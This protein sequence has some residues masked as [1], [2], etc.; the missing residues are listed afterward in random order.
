MTHDDFLPVIQSTVLVELRL[1]PREEVAAA[2]RLRGGSHGEG[3][4]HGR[5]DEDELHGERRVGRLEVEGLN[6][7]QWYAGGDGLIEHKVS[8]LAFPLYPRNQG[9]WY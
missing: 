3:E 4:A 2:R 1:V 7:M 5:C 6:E 8:G 9:P